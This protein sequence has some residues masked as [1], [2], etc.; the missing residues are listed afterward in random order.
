MLCLKCFECFVGS[1]GEMCLNSIRSESVERFFPLA[2]KNRH[3]N[4]I[5]AGSHFVPMR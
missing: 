4:L 1:Q 2:M 3:T 5:I